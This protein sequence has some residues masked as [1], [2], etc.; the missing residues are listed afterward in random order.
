MLCD[1]VSGKKLSSLIN[2]KHNKKK[3]KIRKKMN[4]LQHPKMGSINKQRHIYLKKINM[5]QR[6]VNTKTKITV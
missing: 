1:V 2:K 5:N 6:F 3:T 4:L